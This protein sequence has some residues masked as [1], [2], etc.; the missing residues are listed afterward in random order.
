MM[1]RFYLHLFNHEDVPDEEGIERDGLAEAKATAIV[2][3]RN[4][5]AESVIAG[6]ELDLNHRIDI[7]DE[8]G[9][10]LA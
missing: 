1:P 9:K 7:A 5:M 3:A 4:L 2:G 6:Q 10:V 8:H